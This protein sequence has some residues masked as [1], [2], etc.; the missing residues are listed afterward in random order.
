[1]DKPR[2]LT[3]AE[4]AEI[5]D[6]VKFGLRGPILLK[7]VEWLLADRDERIRLEQARSAREL[8]RPI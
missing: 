8:R 2:L 6:G 3:E 7:W 5:R 4:I 1:M